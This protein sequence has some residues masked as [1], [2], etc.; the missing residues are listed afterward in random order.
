M[1]RSLVQE[2]LRQPCLQ[3]F[4]QVCDARIKRPFDRTEIQYDCNVASRRGSCVIQLY[5]MN[6]RL[7][8]GQDGD[9]T[10]RDTQSSFLFG[11]N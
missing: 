3:C 2:H 11:S 1:K 4:Q 5:I 6:G 9:A 8:L 7:I 10:A